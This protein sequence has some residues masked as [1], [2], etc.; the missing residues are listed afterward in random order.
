MHGIFF[1][2]HRA[3]KKIMVFAQMACPLPVKHWKRTMSVMWLALLP[4]IP[5]AVAVEVG[6]PF[7]SHM[8][9]QQKRAVPVWGRGDAGETVT[10]EF[11]GQKKSTR[12]GDDGRWQVRLDPLEASRVSRTFVVRGRDGTAP[13]A[14]EDVVVGDVWLCGGQSNMERLLGADHGHAIT[15]HDEAVAASSGLPLVRQLMVQHGFS[16][17]PET[18]VAGAW[19][20]CSP[21]TVDN[22][23]AVGYFMARDLFHASGVPIGIINCSYGGSSAEAWMSEAAIAGFPELRQRLEIARALPV[24]AAKAQA[25]FLGRLERWFRTYD[26]GS[27]PSVWHQ[28]DFNTTKWPT[29]D[30]PVIWEKAGHPSVD[31]VAWF[32]KRFALPARW[33]GRDLK[34]NLGVID[35]G[36]AVWINGTR[37]GESYR[38]GEDSRYR[39]PASLLRSGENV[40][41][42][43][44]LDFGNDGGFTEPEHEFNLTPNDAPADELSLRGPWRF[45]FSVTSMEGLPLPPQEPSRWMIWVP[46]SLYNAMLAPLIPFAIRGV[47]FYQGETNVYHANEYVR[48]FPELIADWRHAWGEGDI[49]FLFVQVAP[50]RSSRPEIREAQLLA[51][52]KTI[53]TAMIV[54]ADCGDADNI[55]PADKQ[56]VGARLALAARALGNGEAIEYSGPVYEKSATKQGALVL[57]FSHLGGGLVAKGGPLRGF[58]VAGRDGV[59]HPARGEIE[60][61]TVSLSSPEVPEPCAARYGWANL[62]DGNLY[63]RAG[64]PASPF[65]TDDDGRLTLPEPGPLAMEKKL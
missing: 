28:A 58:A 39:V 43:R 29:M 2:T 30:L 4:T 60:D 45:R 33:S 18:S 32:Q 7:S 1:Q 52:R 6:S 49:P 36:G 11:S 8:V 24:E 40:I 63:N 35:D 10:V 64:L 62:P 20:V 37:V 51:W 44:V 21:A 61:E 26:I 50:Y 57:S 56:T 12:V 38:W 47:A 25:D 5:S 23:S 65:L 34:L 15:K 22:F 19:S 41:T 27:G 31:G 55:H 46:S 42:L 54:T 13:V 59:F 48:L 17:A 53:N 9:L 3:N 16:F 14:I